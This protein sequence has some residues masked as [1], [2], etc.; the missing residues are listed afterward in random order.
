[1]SKQE[2]ALLLFAIV[3]AII[4]VY[5]LFF[6]KDDADDMDAAP[7]RKFRPV[8]NTSATRSCPAGFVL[9]NGICTWRN[10]IPSGTHWPL[11]PI[12]L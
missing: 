1:M 5:Y 7:E 3:A 10:A 8:A 11:P 12:I 4:V 6:R 2:R 9:I